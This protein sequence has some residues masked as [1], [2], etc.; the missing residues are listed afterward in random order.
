MGLQIVQAGV[1]RAGR[2]LKAHRYLHRQGFSM[3]TQA[4]VFSKAY[5]SWQAGKEKLEQ[6]LS[7]Q[8]LMECLRALHVLEYGR[9]QLAGLQTYH[10]QAVS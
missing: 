4:A 5:G 1:H 6:R 3:L 9:Q 8:M 2:L 7:L 10:E